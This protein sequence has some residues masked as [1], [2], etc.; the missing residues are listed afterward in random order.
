MTTAITLRIDDR[1]ISATAGQTILEVARANGAKIPTLCHLDGVSD[2]GAC[3]LCLVEENGTDRLFSSCTTQVSEGMQVRSSSSRLREY[4]RT[5]LEL[6]FAEGNH[7]C[8]VCVAGGHCELQD[9]A[10]ELG[11]DHVRFEYQFPLRQVDVTHPEFGLDHN[12]CILCTRCV[13][14]CHEIEGAHVW[15][16]GGRGSNCQVVAD[17]NQPWGEAANCTS[18][19]KCVEACPTGAIFRKGATIAEM[20]K[21]RKKL[22]FLMTAREKQQWLG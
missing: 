13:R 14:T 21:D 17:L 6:L 4:R 11:M 9:L 8:A 16:V 12:R 18:C 20:Q 2:V 22:Q 5:I 1:L 10:A 19:G 7:V 3:R 15:D